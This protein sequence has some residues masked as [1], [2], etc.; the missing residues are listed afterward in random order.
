MSLNHL[1]PAFLPHYQSPS[2]PPI[3]LYNS[4]TMSFPLAQLLCGMPPQIITTHALP[5]N[6]PIG[7]DI[8][9]LPLIR[10]KN[11]PKQD[12]ETLQPPPGSSSLQHQ[13]HC[14][15]AIHQIIQQF[16]QHLKTEQ[17]DRKTL[18]F[19]A[20]QYQKD[21]ASL[22]YLLFSSVGTTSISDIAVKNSAASPLINSNPI[23]NPN[24]TSTAFPIPCTDDPKLRRSNPEGAVGPP[25]AKTLNSTNANFQSSTNTLETPHITAQNLTSRFS[26]L[27]KLFA[28][29]I[30]TFTSITAGIHSKFFFLI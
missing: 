9:N 25:R 11:P 5:I 7:N 21:F 1:A 3:S 2:N 26:K 27:E 20:L 10:P 28:G 19:I 8:F 15:Q 13:A 6:Q 24:R 22:R 18:Q 17:L 30:A 29:E 4:T 23:P 16:H 12:A 14:L